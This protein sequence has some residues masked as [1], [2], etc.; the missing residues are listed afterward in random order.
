VT[1]IS[2]GR[3]NPNSLIQYK[4]QKLIG[5]G[6]YGKVYSGEI[7]NT[8]EIIAIKSVRVNLFSYLLKK[9]LL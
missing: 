9:V 7:V 3:I 8:R 4:K 1:P 6:S 5:T 2:L